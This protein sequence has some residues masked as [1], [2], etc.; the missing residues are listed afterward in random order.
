MAV[1]IPRGTAMN[2]GRCNRYRGKGHKMLR[3]IGCIIVIACTTTFGMSCASR[4]GIR[5]KVLSGLISALE[6][7][8]S[9]ICDR[10]TPIP[11]LMGTLGRETEPPLRSLFLSCTDQMQ[12]LGAKSFYFM[13]KHAVTKSESL[14]LNDREQKTLIELGHVLG[15]YDTVEQSKAISYCIKRFD[16]YLK[17][18]EEDKKS[19][20]KIHAVLGVAAGFFAV[21]VLI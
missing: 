5:V 2:C 16:Q 3:I 10:L 17:Q 15:R 4:L 12:N 19:Q 1:K 21:I 20:S 7:M 8:R 11:E 13:W 18:A 6:V 9:E 14:E